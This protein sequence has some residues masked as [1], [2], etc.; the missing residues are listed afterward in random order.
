LGN[1]V[2]Q[3]EFA[4][5]LVVVVV[6][7][8]L[9]LFFSVRQ[10]R[11]LRQLGRQR[12][13]ADE[14]RAYFLAQARRRLVASVLMLVLAGVVIGWY[15]IAP[16]YQEILQQARERENKDAPPNPEQKEF[17]QRFAT[18]WIAALGVLFLFVVL[19]IFDILATLKYGVRKH[20][21]LRDQHRAEL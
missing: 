17:L 1:I 16:E 19:A 9:G 15:Y 8:A 5:G 14:E 20:R 13:I 11:T 21:Q 10:A 7:V 2:G 4:F 3:L 6:L 18:Y 12:D